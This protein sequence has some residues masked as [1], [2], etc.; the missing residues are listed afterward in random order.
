M[1][2]KKLLS[3]GC[4]FTAH[5]GFDQNIHK[6]WL[7]QFAK[8]NNFETTNLGLPGC[9]NAEIFF[10]TVEAISK[11]ADY[12]FVTVQW[13][14]LHRLWVYHNDKNIDDYTMV[15]GTG[16]GGLH[17][18]SDH[19]KTYQ[20]IHHGYFGNQYVALKQWLL[21]TIALEVFLK[22][23]NLKF[24]FILGAQNYLDTIPKISYNKD[25]GF[26]NTVLK[27]VDDIATYFDDMFDTK[28][29]ADDLIIE[30]LSDIQNLIKQSQCLTWLN[31]D[32]KPF[33]KLGPD[34]DRADDNSHP[35]PIANKNL[36]KQL[37]DYYAKLDNNS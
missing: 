22:S 34:D 25:T 16:I 17:S 13:T 29:N 7:S 10:R 20:K 12:D 37:T 30:K 14:S 5:S 31:F 1:K 8:N 32:S 6:H 19:V 3:I 35:G 28:N 33:T 26:E 4:S 18:D 9:S 36:C 15:N 21:Y 24:V 27:I 23:Q 11:C 2:N